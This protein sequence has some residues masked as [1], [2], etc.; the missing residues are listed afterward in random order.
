M[1]TLCLT[2][3]SVANGLLIAEGIMQG[4]RYMWGVGGIIFLST[5]GYIYY[6]YTTVQK[7]LKSLKQQPHE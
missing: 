1:R 3:Q 2:I 7:M 6:T 5:I 4:N